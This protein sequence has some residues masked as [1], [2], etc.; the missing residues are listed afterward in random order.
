MFHTRPM[1]GAALGA[2]MAA[3]LCTFVPDWML[4]CFCAALI[5]ISAFLFRRHSAF[6]LLPFVLFLVLARAVLL[7]TEM[8]PIPFLTNLRNSLRANA[9]A[10]FS[11]RAAAAKGI[12]LGDRTALGTEE[13]TQY[14]D[15]G[16]LHL[17]AVSGLHVTLL[18]GTF[19]RL[20]R[21]DRKWLSFAAVALFLLFLC[22]VTGFSASVLRAAFMLLGIRLTRMHDRQVDTPSVYC[23]AMACTLL[24]DPLSLSSIGFQL[25][26]AAAGGMVLLSKSLRKPFKTRFPSSRIVRALSAAISATVGMLPLH[27]YYFGG[28]AWISIPLSIVLIPTMPVILLFGFSAVLLYG[29]LPHAAT[30][31]S[32]PAY[33][34]MQLLYLITQRLDAPLLSLP[35]PHPW[36][37]V[38]WYLGLLFCSRLFLPNRKRPPWIGLALLTGSVLIWFLV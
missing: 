4:L 36:A 9:D 14:R 1:V 7:P 20:V 3:I 8:P 15:A 19:E 22:A 18:V 34:A 2:V 37:I 10:L 12:L 21:S 35:A 31:L 33:G 24:A 29:V 5:P 11:D 27:A 30:L 38:L 13:L 23:F 6:F 28:L 25:S 26:F 17:F 32:Y 16:L